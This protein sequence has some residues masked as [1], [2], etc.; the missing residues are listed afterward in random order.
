MFFLLEQ[1]IFRVGL[2]FHRICLQKEFDTKIKELNTEKNKLYGITIKSPQS[3]SKARHNI[4]KL[5]DENSQQELQRYP[6]YLKN[7]DKIF[8]FKNQ[9]TFLEK[10]QQ[11]LIEV[12]NKILQLN[13]QKSKTISSKNQEK[14][15][16]FEKELKNLRKLKI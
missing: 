12:N 3:R 6:E 9:V 16:I 2:F 5:E 15:I 13:E 14:I 1:N 11:E 7:R 4:D 8:A 10:E